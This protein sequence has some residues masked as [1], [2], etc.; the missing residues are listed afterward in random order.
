[1]RVITD[2]KEAARFFSGG[3]A[4]TIGTY[5]GVHIGHAT[6]LDNLVSL[7]RTSGLKSC[8]VTFSPHPKQIVAP[9]DS[10]QLLTTT[11]E[12]LEFL[13]ARD[14]DAT[15]I[16]NFDRK[17][18]RMSAREFLE[19]YL[20]EQLQCKHLMIGYNHAFGHKREGDTDFLRE[21]A[22]KYGYKF[23]ITEPIILGGEPVH[24]SRIRK[25]I[26][27]GDYGLALKMLGHD[28][29]IIG[30][31]VRGKGLGRDLG[32]PTI[33]LRV[34]PEKLV[35]PSGVYAA[36]ALI[37][38]RRHYGMVFIPQ[39]A[40]GFSLEMNLFDFESDLYNQCIKVC[41]TRFMRKSIKFE[42]PEDLVQQINRDKLEITNV[43][44]LNRGV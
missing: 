17:I 27:K 38:S 10:P 33:N 44:N 23:T 3:S 14:I 12:K 31:V 19:S 34:P 39:T 2:I 22:D 5:D 6:I 20:V 25:E 1:M 4:V 30:N 37:E 43:L 35:P 18:A 21:N 7:A 36:H 42:S 29:T 15:V 11:E 24:S 28:F 26:L 13:R 16:I 9:N 8:L 32:Y 40:E 41:P